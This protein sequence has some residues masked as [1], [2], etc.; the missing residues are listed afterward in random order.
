MYILHRLDT[1]GIVK[2][3]INDC[4]GHSLAPEPGF[5][6][7][8]GLTHLYL[9]IRF[10]IVKA[11]HTHH[12]I[13]YRISFQRLVFV[14]A[15]GLLPHLLHR[16]NKRQPT[17]TGHARTVVARNRH[18]IIPFAGYYNPHPLFPNSLN[19]LGAYGQVGRIYR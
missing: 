5:M 14:L 11:V 10:P 17:D 19:I 1:I 7:L 13:R 2:A 16:P 3:R 12:L 6:Q 4:N 15:G 18:E 9:T 8:I